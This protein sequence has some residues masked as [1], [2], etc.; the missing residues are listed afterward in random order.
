MRDNALPWVLL[1]GLSFGCGSDDGGA[2]AGSGGSS[3]TGGSAG[4]GGT[5]DGDGSEL[6]SSDI[7]SALACGEQ[8]AVSVAMKNTGTTTWTAAEGYKLGA[9][10]D[11]DPLYLADVRVLLG[12][13]DLVA[14]G[15]THTFTFELTGPAAAGSYTSDWQMVKEGVHWF[16]ESTVHAVGVSCQ[17]GKR[18]GIVGLSGNSLVDDQG[19]FNALGATMMWAA[20]GYK[21]DLARLEQ[22]LD[23]LSKNGF[24]YIRALGVVGDPAGA[25]YWDGREIDDAW[26]DYDQVIAGLT[27]LAYDTYGLRVEWTL[28]GDGQVSVPSSAEKAALVD[29]FVQMSQGREHKIIHFEIANEF[30][31]NG[32]S[33]QSGLDELRALSLDL[34]NKTPILVAASAPAG[35]ACSDADAVYAGGIAD[36]ATIHFDRDISQAEGNWRPVHMPWL[37]ELCVPELPVGSNNEPIGPGSSVNTENDPDKLVAGAIM[38]HLSGLPLHVFHSSA[39]VRGDTNLFDM[40]GAGAFLPMKS[41]VPNDLAS[42]TRKEASASDAPFIVYA[43]SGGSLEPNKTWLEVAGADSGVVRAHGAVNGTQFFVFPI[44]IL[45]KV[46]MEPRQAV[47][48]DVIDPMTGATTASHTLGAGQTFELAGHEALVLRGNYQ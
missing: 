47:S 5:T 33:G 2:A 18:T 44:G 3:G 10:D 4:S 36:I 11:S 24:D 35:S 37:H 48:F 23:F 17:G 19:A 46:V 14:P 38:T 8:R 41:I 16:G 39:G 32:F 15:D 20:W 42:F 29:R 25:D 30:W 43:G 45:N 9:V 6:V 21:F 28:I 27:D 22:N 34:K 40:S 31:Q 13:S 1:A 12:P 7:P 26:P